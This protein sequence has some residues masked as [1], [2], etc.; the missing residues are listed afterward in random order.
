MIAFIGYA[1]SRARFARSHASVAT[2]AVALARAGGELL[3]TVRIL[4]G[5]ANL[6]AEPMRIT[7]LDSR[8]VPQLPPDG[9]LA[10]MADLE[11]TNL[12]FFAPIGWQDTHNWG[13]VGGLSGGVPVALAD[14][15]GIEAMLHMAFRPV[16]HARRRTGY[17]RAVR[18]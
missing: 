4:L 3:E 18:T 5:T 10:V 9:A 16:P 13:H 8:R 7:R 14:V 12:E 6:A 15:E 2:A 11:T 1:G 17:V